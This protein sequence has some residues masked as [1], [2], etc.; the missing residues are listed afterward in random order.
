M[1]YT[2]IN[3]DSISYVD[4]SASLHTRQQVNKIRDKGYKI[5]SYF[6]KEQY[7]SL[8][9]YNLSS[10]TTEV[11]KVRKQF[12]TMYGKDASFINV[13]NIFDIAKTI[14]KMFLDKD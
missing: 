1:A 5:L 10:V 8:Y 11:D 7:E 14:N 9:N 6:I 4:E 2:D 3:G 12:K 13:K